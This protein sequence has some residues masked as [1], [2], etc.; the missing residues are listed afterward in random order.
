MRGAGA[1]MEIA[2]ISLEP[3]P[4]TRQDRAIAVV[5]GAVTFT[6]CPILFGHTISTGSG[7]VGRM[8]R[9]TGLPRGACGSV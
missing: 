9:G 8:P 3:G 2:A 7:T 4:L 1:A 5:I 6:A